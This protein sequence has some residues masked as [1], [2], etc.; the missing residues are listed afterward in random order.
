MTTR[1]WD[2]P[3]RW[4]FGDAITHEAD[5]RGV[6]STSRVPD[7]DVLVALE[8]SIS[9]WRHVLHAAHAPTSILRV[10]GVRD[11]ALGAPDDS[12]AITVTTDSYE[13]FRALAGR[14]SAQQVRQWDWNADPGPYL[15]AGLAFPFHW[16]G[17]AIHD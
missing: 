9:R 10:P 2:R 7:Y 6:D 5:L 13:V 16:A 11:D 3:P 12:D 15:D 1:A 8:G 17:Q 14:R 4:A